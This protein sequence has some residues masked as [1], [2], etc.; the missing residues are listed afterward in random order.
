[1]DTF[2]CGP[3]P[4]IAWFVPNI[5]ARESLTQLYAPRGLGKT[6]IA[7]HWAVKLAAQGLR[8]LIL[9]RDNSRRTVRR[10]L[11][12]FEAEHLTTLRVISREKCPPLTQPEAWASFPYAEY[13]VVVVDSL[14][15]MAEGVGEQDSAKPAK[16]MAPLL[17]ICHR[18]GGPAVLLLGNTIKSGEHSRG[19]G[20]NED[21]ADIVFEVRDG[22][23]FRPSGTKPWIEE[24]PAQGASEWAA[25]S[26][27]RKGRSDFRVALVATKCRDGE[28]PAP[29][30]LEARLGDIPYTV[31]DVTA[32]VDAV[33]EAERLR[34][35]NEKQE[36]YQLGLELLLKEMKRRSENS[37]K[38]IL[39]EP[40]EQFLMGIETTPRITRKEART[41]VAS[42]RIAQVKG[43]GKGHP[44]ELHGVSDVQQDVQPRVEL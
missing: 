8:V 30:M 4:E 24:L 32:S 28:E 26:A 1:M 3:E 5:L 36:R 33:G 16:A 20:V 43:D 25:R 21:R 17:D 2:L 27:R 6:I 37:D 22:T 11:C 42:P 40:A 44:I 18:E 35:A 39:K 29:L 31:E 19:S 12:G 34:V 9:D 15:A 7:H 38:P 14:D 41:I 10:R 23:G 13:D